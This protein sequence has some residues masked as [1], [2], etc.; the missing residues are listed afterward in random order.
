MYDDSENE[1]QLYFIGTKH[2]DFVNF[3]YEKGSVIIDPWRFI[4]DIYK[5]KVIRIGDNN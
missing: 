1:S 5:C 2:E 3:P 4:P